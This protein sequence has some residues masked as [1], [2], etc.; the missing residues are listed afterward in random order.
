MTLS[1]ARAAAA[2]AIR[3]AA[4]DVEVTRVVEVDVVTESDV[5]MLA[6]G[7][8]DAPTAESSD[9]GPAVVAVMA[10]GRQQSQAIDLTAFTIIRS[11]LALELAMA[12]KGRGL[13]VLD[14]V[15]SALSN[16]PGGG[17]PRLL[18]ETIAEPVRP[19]V[20]E[21]DTT[22]Q[23]YASM[24]TWPPAFP[25][26]PEGQPL[27]VA[28]GDGLGAFRDHLAAGVAAAGD[29][30]TQAD[31]DADAD[32]ADRFAADQNRIGDTEARMREPR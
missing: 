32:L 9:R 11:R 23:V 18:V 20:R 22:I 8:W 1:Q 15:E 17:L 19:P 3:A 12:G 27:A 6:D 7:L 14:Q 26:E 25:G 4:S 24:A 28:E 21:T 13:A 31:V 30:L 2:A 29:F 16:L 10:R 5:P